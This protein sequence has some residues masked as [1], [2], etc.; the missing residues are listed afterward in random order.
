MT[1]PGRGPIGI[2]HY[3]VICEWQFAATVVSNFIS[4]LAAGPTPFL[5]PRK[6]T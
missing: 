4:E 1:Q 2:P 5:C 6:G 3:I